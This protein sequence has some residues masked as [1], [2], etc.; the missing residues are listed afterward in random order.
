MA[1]LAALSER[2]DCP[3]TPIGRILAGTDGEAATRV[4]CRCPDGSTWTPPRTGF[5][6]FPDPAPD[7][8]SSP[9]PSPSPDLGLDPDPA[10]G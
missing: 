3:L 2:L 7:T 4:I 1:S 9:S 6:H 5:N 10:P 8:A